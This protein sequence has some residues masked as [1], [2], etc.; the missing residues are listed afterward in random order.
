MMVSEQELASHSFSEKDAIFVTDA[1]QIEFLKSASNTSLREGWMFPLSTQAY[2]PILRLGHTR[3]R[4]YFELVDFAECKRWYSNRALECSKTWLKELDLEFQFEGIDIAKLDAPCQFHLF[5]HAIYIAKTAERLILATPEIETFYVIE[6]G[7]RLPL[8]FYFD[9]D[10]PAAVLRFVCE[11]L[12]RP[13]RTIVMKRRPRYVFP[14]FQR[15]PITNARADGMIFDES[16]LQIPRSSRSRVGFAPRSP[17]ISKSSMPS[18]SSG[19]YWWYFRRHGQRRRPLMAAGQKRTNI[20]T[21][22]LM[23]M[24]S[25]RWKF[26]CVWQ[27]CGGSF[28]R[29]ALSRHSRV[30]SLATRTWTSNLITFSRDDGCRTPT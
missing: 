8:D 18:A 23:L 3:V 19:V 15:R 24:G 4:S 25:G 11:R 12:S 2:A 26:L 22:C 9:S 6:A 29:S 27:I 1:V 14:A 17:I 21:N 7:Q 5:I 30:A 28:L 13:V 16:T 10:V 20:S